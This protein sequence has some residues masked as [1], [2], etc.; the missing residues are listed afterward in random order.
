MK[1]VLITGASSGIG[2]E[3]AK[4]YIDRGDRVA[5]IGRRMSALEDLR[6]QCGEVATLEIFQ[7]DVTDAKRMQEIVD[8][9]EN[10]GHPVDIAIA[11]AG[12]SMHTIGGTFDATSARTIYETNVI[13][14]TNTIGAVLPR[15]MERKAG[16]IVGVSSLA[17][18]ISIPRSSSYCASKAAVSAQLIGLRRD[19]KRH[20]ITVTTICP[21][22]IKTPMT[23]KNR[24]KMP[25]LWSKIHRCKK[26]S[27]ISLDL[28]DV[29]RKRY[30][31]ESLSLAL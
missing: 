11:N 7:G 19:L 15:M 5:A 6:K 2:F 3:L 1:Q 10:N 27:Q 8:T 18:Y 21:G 23:A 20:G 13:G 12:V 24:F 9:L 29:K 17:S 31:D 22:F 4:Q 25:F 28:Y 16:Q 14:V 30:Q 26:C